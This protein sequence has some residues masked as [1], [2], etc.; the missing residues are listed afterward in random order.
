M[1]VVQLLMLVELLLQ[2]AVQHLPLLMLMLR[3]PVLVKQLVKLLLQ[4]VQLTV[5]IQLLILLNSVHLAVKLLH[6][7]EKLKLLVEQ[8][9]LID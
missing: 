3:R 7:F 2:L 8:S 4:I 6:H 9:V 5:Q 1:P